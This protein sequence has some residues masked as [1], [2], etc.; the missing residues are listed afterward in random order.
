MPNW[1]YGHTDI[2]GTKDAILSFV[3]RFIFPDEPKTLMG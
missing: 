2:T 3:N 1:A